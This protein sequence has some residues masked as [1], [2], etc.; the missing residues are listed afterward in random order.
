MGTDLLTELVARGLSG[1]EVVEAFKQTDR[2]PGHVLVR[3]YCGGA[4]VGGLVGR[5]PY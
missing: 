5:N 2:V 1:E 4:K 3:T